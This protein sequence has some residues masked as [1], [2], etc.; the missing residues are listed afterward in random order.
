V[1]PSM[2]T[3]GCTRLWPAIGAVACLAA[4]IAGPSANEVAVAQWNLEQ[5]PI[6]YSHA[7]H[8]DPVAA[9]AEKLQQGKVA[10]SHSS[11]QGYLPALLREL[12][13]S[14]SSQTLVFSKTSF[15]RT[16]ISPR[17][18]RAIYFNDESYVGYVQ[19]GEVL[20]IS[21]IDPRLGAV[22]YTLD[23]AKADHPR[24]VR[25]T[26]ECLQCHASPMTENVPGHMVR[27]VFPRRSGNPVLSAGTFRTTYQSPLEERWGGWY[28]TG[29]HGAQ[30]HM[31]NAF[32]SGE[33]PARFDRDSGANVT[34]LHGRFDFAPY[35]TPHSD[36]V[37][38]MVLEHQVATHN[39]F[40]QAAYQAQ[41]AR[42]EQEALNRM[43][44]DPPS[45][46]I[47]SIER[48]YRAAADD[49]LKC[50][51]FADEARLT[52]PIRGTSGFAEH[53][54][55]LGPRDKRGRSLRQFDLQKRLFKVPCSSLIYSPAFDGLPEPVKKHVSAR[56][57][58]I[59][60]GEDRSPE[61]SH[62]NADDRRAIHEILSE[63]KPDL[64][65]SWKKGTPTR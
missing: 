60:T 22:F 57:E 1:N 18:P 51:L 34:D 3:C 59:L 28:V 35:L 39:Q 23:Q 41:F 40:T 6:N 63:T 52:D 37:A 13:I 27:S 42:V 11:R 46:P 2:R 47:E 32:L 9:L 53:F 8:H 30:R 65:E 14:E 17:R 50:L 44:G 29:T 15:Q 62:L 38:L 16:K 33:D 45:T 7:S 58:R 43:S 4:A 26:D 31:G 36:I 55:S 56:L 49:V 25:Q 54:A 10:L 19:D 20:E 48:R 24:L 5:E 64:A 61:F 12:G 21:S